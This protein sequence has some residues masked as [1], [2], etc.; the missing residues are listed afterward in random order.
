MSWAGS[1]R[2]NWRSKVM[3]G[4]S[5][6]QHLSEEFLGLGNHLAVIGAFLGGPGFGKPALIVLDRPRNRFQC[7]LQ[8]AG[9]EI[10]RLAARCLTGDN[11]CLWRNA[12]IGGKP[13][14]V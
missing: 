11:F 13:L 2:I 10:R 6:G 12:L 8:A 5:I 7:R 9:I 3:V 1:R 4:S 14:R